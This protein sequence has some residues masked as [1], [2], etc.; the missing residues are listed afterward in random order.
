MGKLSVVLKPQESESLKG[1]YGLKFF[2][3]VEDEKPFFTQW[4]ANGEDVMVCGHENSDVDN[5]HCASCFRKYNHDV[6]MEWIQCPALWQPQFSLK[7]KTC[8]ME[9]FRI[10]SLKMSFCRTKAPFC[11]RAPILL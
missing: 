11:D 3:L 9:V 7:V 2:Y 8:A 4:Y 5:D 10:F 6:S 1:V